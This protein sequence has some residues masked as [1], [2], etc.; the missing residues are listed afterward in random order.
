MPSRNS[1]R[2]TG[3]KALYIFDPETG[4]EVSSVNQLGAGPQIITT[5]DM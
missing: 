3:D 1:T 2:S 5:A 4:K